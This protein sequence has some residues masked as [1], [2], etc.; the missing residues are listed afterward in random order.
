MGWRLYLPESWASDAQRRSEAGIPEGI[1]FRQK[2]ELALEIIDQI[3]EWGL[4]DRVVLGDAGYGDGTEFREELEKRELKYA[5]GVQPQVGLWL[6]PPKITPLQTTGKGRLRTASR[7]GEQR[8]STAQEAA[9]QAKAWRKIRWRPRCVVACASQSARQRREVLRRRK[10]SWHRRPA[11][12]QRRDGR[13]HRQGHRHRSV[14]TTEDLR[15]ILPGGA[16]KPDIS[17]LQRIGH[18]YFALTSWRKTSVSVL[19][20]LGWPFDPSIKASPI[21]CQPDQNVRPLSEAHQSPTDSSDEST[22]QWPRPSEDVPQDSGPKTCACNF[23]KH[24]DLVRLLSPL[25]ELVQ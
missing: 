19:H 24:N 14:R 13:D 9:T 20:S 16:A 1:V 3:R 10:R 4:P 12:G 5:V 25:S 18:F 15:A 8:P 11:G 7:Y 22:F 23:S 21:G 17:T 2:G 6:K